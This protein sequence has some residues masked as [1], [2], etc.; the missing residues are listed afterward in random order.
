[1]QICKSG[2]CAAKCLRV[3]RSSRTTS[4]AERPPPGHRGA[5][6]SLAKNSRTRAGHRRSPKSFNDQ[7]RLEQPKIPNKLGGVEVPAH[8]RNSNKHP[9]SHNPS[10][11]SPGKRVKPA[12][13]MRPKPSKLPPPQT[14]Q[15]PKRAQSKTTHC[16]AIRTE[17]RVSKR[18]SR[19]QGAPPPTPPLLTD[20]NKLPSI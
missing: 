1:M 6:D 5:A 8:F 16:R 15:S 10:R 13:P 9:P 20:F 4:I 17:P 11:T 12:A 2:R 3:Q 7:V 14:P 18:W 19:R